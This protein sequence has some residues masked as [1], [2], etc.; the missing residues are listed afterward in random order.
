MLG[1]LALLATDAALLAAISLGASI[2]STKVSR[3]FKTTAT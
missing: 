2:T 3:V 1:G